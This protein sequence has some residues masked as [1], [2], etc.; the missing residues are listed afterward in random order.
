VGCCVGWG[1]LLAS[2][3]WAYGVCW[4]HPRFVFVQLAPVRR[5]CAICGGVLL[6]VWF[7]FSL[8]VVFSHGD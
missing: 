3:V 4:G 1:L 2:A 7:F 8:G 6:V 5:V